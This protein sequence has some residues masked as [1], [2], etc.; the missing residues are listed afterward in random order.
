MNEEAKEK[1][2]NNIEILKRIQAGNAPKLSELI[3]APTLT[4]WRVVA[5][6][7]PGGGTY[8]EGY[9]MGHPRFGNAPVTTSQLV[10]IDPDRRWA[11]TL[12][13]WYKLDMPAAGDRGGKPGWVK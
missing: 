4:G 10:A 9:A 6:P 13:R 7:D 2:R 8:L 1:L 5:S 11:R 12:S 3:D